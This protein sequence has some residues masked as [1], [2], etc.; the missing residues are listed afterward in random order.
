MRVGPCMA[1]CVGMS[2]Y[3]EQGTVLF[4]NHVGSRGW[5]QV[6][7]CGSKCLYPL[8][9]LH[10]L[11]FSPE[12]GA[13]SIAQTG[14][15]LAVQSDSLSPPLRVLELRCVLPHLTGSLILW[16][17]RG[18]AHAAGEGMTGLDM[19]VEAREQLQSNALPTEL[20][21]F[22]REQLTESSQCH[23]DSGLEF[24]SSAWH[25]LLYPLSLLTTLYLD[26]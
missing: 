4:F 3:C 25:W 9:H 19:S 10:I 2:E 23:V 12:V 17:G 14:F 13:C 5:T 24:N 15:A 6:I 11:F 20:F 7:T 8:R 16:W 1:Q 21:R 22:A 18:S 26:H